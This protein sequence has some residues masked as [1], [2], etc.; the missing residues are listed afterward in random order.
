VKK[1]PILLE[2]VS[3]LGTCIRVILTFNPSFGRELVVQ[4]T[5]LFMFSKFSVDAW[6]QCGGLNKEHSILVNW[7]QNPVWHARG[8]S[9]N[10]LRM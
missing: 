3:N 7:G 1:K 2:V 5:K 6:S 9:V 4:H 10:D 8:A